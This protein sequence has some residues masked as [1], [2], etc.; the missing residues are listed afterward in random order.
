MEQGAGDARGDGEEFSL[1][2]EDF[3]LA[4]ARKFGKIDGATTADA[5]GC[6]FVGGDCG[7]LGEEFA[8]VDEE[9]VY[10]W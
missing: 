6:G 1:S 3:D 8:R 7:K 9:G 4:R 10:S 5:G 2:G